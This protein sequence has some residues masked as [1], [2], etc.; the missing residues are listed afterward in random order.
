MSQRAFGLVA[1]TLCLAPL[2]GCSLLVDGALGSRGGSMDGGPRIDG[3]AIDGGNDSPCARFPEGTACSIEGIAESLVCRGGRCELS[4]CGDGITDDREGEQC[5]DGNDRDGDGCD[6]DCTPSCAAASDCDDGRACNGAETCS[7]TATCANGTPL[8]DGTVCVMSEGGAGACRAGVCALVGCGDRMVVP[9]EECDDGNVED[10]D[11]CDSDCTFTCESDT[12]C[13]DG[14][15]CNGTE[16]CAVATHLC[17]PGTAL[18]CPM[19]AC[20]SVTCDPSAGCVYDRSA[21]DRD[22]DGHSV[23]SCGG[24]D[25]NDADETVYPGAPELCDSIDHDC[26]GN[27][28]PPTAPPWYPDCDRDGYANGMVAGMPSCTP[29]TTAPACP[30]GF[31]GVW[32]T[33]I[34]DCND[35]N[36]SVY[37]GQSSWFDRPHSGTNF[38]W[39]CSG[40]TE[41]EF[42]V[43][44][45]RT[46]CVGLRDSCNGAPAWDTRPPGCGASGRPTVCAFA[47]TFP[48]TCQRVAGS[49]TVVDRCH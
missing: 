4:T 9:P 27:P 7:A 47:T 12:E 26:N 40:M 42:E 19:M 34:G 38:D 46:P 49:M 13:S 32:L 15:P 10:G 36:P 35:S 29:P 28:M 3:G 17:S 20:A 48:F 43:A 37:P 39:N 18:E 6:R 1:A 2:A 8:A 21:F 5:D 14:D 41:H 25:C 16:T 31:S 24:D 33:R 23:T 30:A 11:G 44:S 22:G 45:S